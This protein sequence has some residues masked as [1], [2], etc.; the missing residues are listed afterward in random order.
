M[1]L[2]GIQFLVLAERVKYLRRPPERRSAVE[3][4]KRKALKIDV[5]G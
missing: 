1:I 3:Q 2:E 4:D 5:I